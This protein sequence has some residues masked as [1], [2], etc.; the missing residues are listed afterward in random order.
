MKIRS[1]ILFLLQSAKA[2]VIPVL[3]PLSSDMSDSS[4]IE[5]GDGVDGITKRLQPNGGFKTCFTIGITA[6]GKAI[7][8]QVDTGST[9]SAL[10]TYVVND[11]NG[12]KIN[13]DYQLGSTPQKSSYADRSW[14]YI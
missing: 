11:Y 10:A 8:C 13:L 6:L 4:V 9:D 3:L 5:I 12:P 2:D 14:W 1:L 7:N